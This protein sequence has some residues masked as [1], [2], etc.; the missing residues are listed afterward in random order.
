[1]VGGRA[2]EKGER[3]GEEGQSETRGVHAL[4]SGLCMRAW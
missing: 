1:V 2:T 3:R 4:H